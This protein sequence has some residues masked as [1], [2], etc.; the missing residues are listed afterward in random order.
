MAFFKE[1]V[2]WLPVDEC[3]F[4]RC[5]GYCSFF[6]ASMFLLIFHLFKEFGGQGNH[7]IDIFLWMD[8]DI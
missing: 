6:L 8:F 7:Y 2:Y 4:L 1:L 5:T 3:I